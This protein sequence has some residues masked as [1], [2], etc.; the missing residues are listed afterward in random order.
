MLRLTAYLDESGHLKDPTLKFIGMAG[1][2]APADNWGTFAAEW[3]SIL[4]EAGLQEPFH[5]SEF[6]H[7]MGQFARFKDNE[8]ERQLFFK[9]LLCAIKRTQ[10]T[11][12]GAIVSI[13]AF[14]ALT[15]SQRDLFVGPYY[16]A[17]QICT[18][19][20]ALKADPDADECVDM[21][22]S[23]NDEFGTTSNRTR[24]GDEP[25]NGKKLFS[26]M[27]NVPE[28]ERHLGIFSAAAPKDRAELQ[29]ADLFAYELVHEFEN[30][31][32]R[33]N[34]DMRHGL[35]EI[36]RMQAIP[37]PRIDLLDRK[38]LLYLVKRSRF[39]DQTGVEEA[40]EM[41]GLSAKQAMVKWMQGRGRVAPEMHI[42]WDERSFLERP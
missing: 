8:P 24:P 36:L 22:Y 35:G 13:E 23:L 28:Y 9:K 26:A 4:A 1:L 33:P 7:S 15:Q 30:R 31:I 5:M 42:T 12:I 25:G 18:R 6:A 34:Y 38:E 21:V 32:K 2:V 29:A 27:K 3:R 41:V 10:A 39:P 19:Y 17:F 16:L 20:A 11:P 40:D 14:H 37:M